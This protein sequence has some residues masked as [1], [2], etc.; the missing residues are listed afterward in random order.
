[1][2]EAFSDFEWHVWPSYRWREV[3]GPDGAPITV[4][5]GGMGGFDSPAAIEHLWDSADKAGKSIG[6]ELVPVLES[7]NPKRYLPMAREHVAL[8]LEF[9]QLDF[10]QP[11]EM[12]AFANRYGTLGIP[13]KNTGGES[14]VDWAREICQMREGIALA[15]KRTAADEARE[16][17]SWSKY[18][19]LAQA[20][21]RAQGDDYDPADLRRRERRE[22]LAWLFN[23]HLQHVQPRM[24]L[25]E[26]LPARL[27]FEPRNLLSA[28]WLQFAMGQ[29][30]DKRFPKC[31]H[32][33][34]VFEIS[35]DPTTGFRS[36]REFCSPSCKT[37][38]YRKRKRTAQMLA[39]KGKS[40]AE[41]AAALSTER[42]TIH[43]WISA[44]K[45]A[46]KL[47]ESRRGKTT[48]KA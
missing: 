41:I 1:M 19:A 28:M 44:A 31:K 26:H 29:A 7:G 13:S 14:I 9:S 8:F 45:K 42:T 15:R 3:L 35:T 46:S 17:E 38:D 27:R 34:K 21:F 30:G 25:D 2:N 12:L 48:R 24:V 20:H 37:F 40:I 39:T 22:K 47:K 33:Q 10:R 6:P 23:R 11:E 18:D 5:T 43:G 36:N 4:P 16:T 32:C